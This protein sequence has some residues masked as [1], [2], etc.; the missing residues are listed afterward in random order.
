MRSL[1]YLQLGHSHADLFDPTTLRH[2]TEL[3]QLVIRDPSSDSSP[4]MLQHSLLAMLSGPPQNLSLLN[5]SS[6]LTTPW[7]EDERLQVE[8]AARAAKI[9]LVLF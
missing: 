9:K 6:T 5:I 3:R 8:E 4:P 2:L 1:K 7:T